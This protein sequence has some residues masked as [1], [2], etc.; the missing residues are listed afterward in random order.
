[1]R[2]GGLTRPIFVARE[3]C[4]MS[5]KPW[6]KR[7][8]NLWSGWREKLKLHL[9][10]VM[11]VLKRGFYCLIVR[12]MLSLG[13]TRQDISTAIMEKQWEIFFF[14]FWLISGLRKGA[15]AGTDFHD[16]RISLSSQSVK[17]KSKHF[18]HFLRLMLKRSPIIKLGF[19]MTGKMGEGWP[20][21]MV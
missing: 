12:A 19:W 7:I 1:M 10:Q 11:L 18:S 20:C 15:Q 4:I 3:C 14:L 6:Q 17:S 9:F 21:R 8:A 16:A 5:A 13:A 2:S